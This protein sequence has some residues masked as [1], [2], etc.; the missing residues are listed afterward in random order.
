MYSWIE[1]VFWHVRES[2][3]VV[4]TKNVFTPPQTRQKGNSIKEWSLSNTFKW[5]F[6]VRKNTLF[7][8]LNYLYGSPTLSALETTV[9]LPIVIR[10]NVSN[11]TYMDCTMIYSTLI[12]LASLP[13]HLLSLINTVWPHH[14]N[15][16]RHGLYWSISYLSHS[17]KRS[18]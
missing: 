4:R 7:S 16:K 1:Y 12:K 17:R 2:N 14:I 11:I 5:Q 6:A 15:S 13:R 9:E 18:S 3:I 10:I 8:V